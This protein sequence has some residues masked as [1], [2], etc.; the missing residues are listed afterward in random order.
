MN[1][2][3]ELFILFYIVRGN[4]SQKEDRDNNFGFHGNKKNIAKFRS[5]TGP[6]LNS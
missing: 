2:N 6:S 4:I 1:S 5:M 3:S